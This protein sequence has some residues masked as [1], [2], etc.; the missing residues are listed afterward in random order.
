MQQHK[1]PAKQ[2]AIKKD[3][4]KRKRLQPGNFA[5]VSFSVREKETKIP[6]FIE[7]LVEINGSYG[8]TYIDAIIT[9]RKE[10]GSCIV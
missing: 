7:K 6:K 10:I 3:K 9:K 2:I 5:A 8:Y 4:H 1:S